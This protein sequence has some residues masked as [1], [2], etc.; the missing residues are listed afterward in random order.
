M[1]LT[2]N[3]Q[4]INKQALIFC[5]GVGFGILCFIAS[6]FLSELLLARLPTEWC[7]KPATNP[8]QCMQR[9]GSTTPVPCEKK[10]P[11]PCTEPWVE[12]SLRA[13]EAGP[14]PLITIFFWPGLSV[15]KLGQQ[16]FSGLTYGVISGICF[17][18]LGRRWG[19]VLFFVIAVNLTIFLAYF[20]A[21]MSDAY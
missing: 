4:R 5:Q 8:P 18:L 7:E 6:A 10:L 16:V 21:I 1:L 14:G 12:F 3:W 13:T 19:I 11:S 15:S 17:C 2:I 20:F 9:R